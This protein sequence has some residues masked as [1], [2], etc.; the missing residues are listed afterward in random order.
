M[1]CKK[2][3]KSFNF[4]MQKVWK[5]NWFNEIQISSYNQFSIP[6]YNIRT[7]IINSVFA[8][9][10]LSNPKM[11]SP[12]GS[13]NLWRRLGRP[14]ARFPRLNNFSRN[15]NF[16]RE[17]RLTNH[18]MENSGKPVVFWMWIWFFLLFSFGVVM[19]IPF[20]QIIDIKH[21]LKGIYYTRKGS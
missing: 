16:R 1:S 2:N 3:I 13:R 9:H 4:E 8:K 20:D 12:L 18:E 6:V 11:V 15:G 21:A 5:R 14:K 17:F 10:P 7:A 19:E